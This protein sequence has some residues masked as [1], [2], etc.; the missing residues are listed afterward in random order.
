MNWTYKKYTNLNFDENDY[1]N[2]HKNKFKIISEIISMEKPV[3]ILDIGAGVGTIY[4]LLSSLDGI[5][6]H[7]IE[8][9]DDFISTLKER[10]IHAYK[11]DL[12]KERTF[13]FADNSF[14]IV[15]CDSILE[16][17]IK[18]LQLFDES[19]R[20]LKHGGEFIL[21][22]PNATS[23]KR[24][25]AYLRGRNV[26]YPL[27]YNLF[28]NTYLQRCSIFYTQEDLRIFVKDKFSIRNISFIDETYHDEKSMSVR[29]C[30]VLSNYVPKFRDVLIMTGNKI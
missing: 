14:D 21:I 3:K 9:V 24:R 16:H 2:N 23:A 20:V 25:W 15:L 5:D 11:F 4:S 8:F 6:I 13:P 26:F 18:P 19:K 29:I 27:I 30:R 17:T 7:A 10:N 12:D 1:F 22:V 28:H